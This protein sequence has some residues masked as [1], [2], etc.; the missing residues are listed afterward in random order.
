MSNVVSRLIGQANP[1]STSL[2]VH[3]LQIVKNYIRPFEDSKKPFRF[4]Y[5]LISSINRRVETE[6]A[7]K[8]KLVK[9]IKK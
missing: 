9:L 4:V 5:K 6:D 3:V 7:M 8:K 2:I 1:H